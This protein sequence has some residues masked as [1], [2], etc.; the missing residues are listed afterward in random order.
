MVNVQSK[1]YPL[2]LY[3]SSAG[4]PPPATGFPGA[5]GGGYPGAAGGGYPGTGY[6]APPGTGYP[7]PAGGPGFTGQDIL[8]H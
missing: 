5:A 8:Y 2:S 1:Q 4:Y 6:P 7:P 3:Y